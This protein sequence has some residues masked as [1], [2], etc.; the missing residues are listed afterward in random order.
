MCD[1]FGADDKLSS[2]GA[3]N[4]GGSEIPILRFNVQPF[5]QRQLEVEVSAPGE[6]A[7]GDAVVADILLRTDRH[8]IGGY[9][10]V[11]TVT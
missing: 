8:I 5:E 7:S 4:Q 1:A 6:A 10:M 9:T 2:D 11:V 3:C